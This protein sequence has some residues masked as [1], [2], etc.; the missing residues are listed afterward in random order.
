MR[1]KFT[2]LEGGT[3][4]EQQAIADWREELAAPVQEQI[5][6]LVTLKVKDEPDM[7]F[8][9]ANHDVTYLGVTYLKFPLSFKGVSINSD[10]TI[11]NATLE[12][13][14]VSRDL[15]GIIESAKGLS[16]A[17]CSIK[18]ISAKFTDYSYHYL[19][20]IFDKGVYN[21]TESYNELDKTIKDGIDKVLVSDVWEELVERSVYRKVNATASTVDLAIEDFFMVASYTANAKVIVFQLAPVVNVDTKLPRRRYVADTCY[22]K[23]KGAECGYAGGLTTCSKRLNGADGCAGRSNTLRFGGFPG[24]NRSR[25]VML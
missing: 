19:D 3:A 16:R 18:T 21:E 2:I 20:H 25:R 24:V 13:A 14:N 4:A 1:P 7:F 5:Y 17:L 22:W 23:F 9:D 15:M 6:H 11:D 12:V 8:V 10:G